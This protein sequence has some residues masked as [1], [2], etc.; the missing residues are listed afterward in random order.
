MKP[1]SYRGRREAPRPMVRVPNFESGLISEPL[2]AFGG[3]QRHVDPKTGLALYGPYSLVGQT[4]PMLKNII[5][6]IV[7]PPAMIADAEAWLTACRG[8]LTNEGS[9]PFLYPH[10]PGINTQGPFQCE[11]NF[12]DTWRESIRDSEIKSALC[13]LRLRTTSEERCPVVCARS[14]SAGGPRSPARGHT[15]LHAAGGHRQLHRRRSARAHQA[16]AR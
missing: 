9:Q 2:L 11:L 15:L 13:R 12:G 5:V 8:V 7:G 14:G 10:F 6:G 4:V 16:F 1:T 3:Q